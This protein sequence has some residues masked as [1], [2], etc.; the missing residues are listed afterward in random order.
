MGAEGVGQFAEG[1]M[2]LWRLGGYWLKGES[3]YC[4]L[5]ANGHDEILKITNHISSD[6]RLSTGR[7]KRSS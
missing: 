4:G 5:I 7:L 1:M 2:P 3:R 6:N